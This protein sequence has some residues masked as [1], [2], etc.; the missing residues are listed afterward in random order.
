MTQPELDE[1]T[2]ARIRAEELERVRVRE[3]LAAEERLR[4]RPSYAVG[5]VLNLL[6]TGAGLMYAR[7]VTAGLLWLV[8]TL[9]LAFLVSPWVAWPIG[10]IGSFW[11]YS[12]V[13]DHLYEPEPSA[14]EV[15]AANRTTRM[16]LLIIGTVIL[17][18][19]ILTRFSR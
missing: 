10:L 9:A 17:L 7:Q 3:E 13:Y 14:E 18:T 4:N 12:T 1:A 19:I 15:A 2:K 16:Y 6:L 11:H 5:A 8:G